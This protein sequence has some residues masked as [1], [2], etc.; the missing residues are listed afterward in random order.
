[1]WGQLP[2]LP[3]PPPLHLWPAEDYEK[4]EIS[5]ARQKLVRYDGYNCYNELWI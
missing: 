4:V 3:P 2:S 5:I 1:M